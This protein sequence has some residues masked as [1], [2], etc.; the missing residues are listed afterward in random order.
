MRGCAGTCSLSAPDARTQLSVFQAPW[1]SCSACAL[2][3]LRRQRQ[4]R[5]VHGEGPVGRIMVIGEGPGWQEEEQGRPFIGK[6]GQLLRSV[7]DA[8]KILEHCYFANAVLCRSCEPVLDPTTGEPL[9][10]QGWPARP[11]RPGHP[12]T[13]AKAPEPRMRDV[14]PTTP[15]K[16]ACLARLLEEI[17]LVDPLLIVS[18]GAE[19]TEV[20]VGKSI[21]ILAARGEVRELQVPGAMWKPSL[22]EKAGKW[23]RKVKGEITAPVEQNMVRYLLLPTIHPAFVLKKEKDDGD[24]G[25]ARLF[26]KD[27]A[28]VR[29]IYE[30]KMRID[31]HV[32]KR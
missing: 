28:K 3:D 26:A 11:A 18:L 29:D 8:F 21:S 20:L 24:T 19:S 10:S 1:E 27:L 32:E 14:A 17:Y 6:S 15:Q 22:T 9:M 2:G 31:Q 13:P 7:L 5:I 25:P 12:A 30:Q 4:K 23:A 16:Q